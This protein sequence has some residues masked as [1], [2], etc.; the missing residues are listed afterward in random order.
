MSFSFTA[1]RSY[2][3]LLSRLV[4]AA[5]F[6]PVGWNR[7]MGDEHV[8][9]GREARIL[10]ELGVGGASGDRSSAAGWEGPEVLA[11]AAQNVATGTLVERTAPGSGPA[12]Q[13]GRGN[14]DPDHDDQP[15]A[16]VPVPPIQ[17][18]PTPAAPRPADDSAVRAKPIYQDAVRLTERGLGPPRMPAWLPIWFARVAA[19]IELVGAGLLVVGLLSRVW[20][21]GLCAL[22]AVGLYTTS[23]SAALQFGL[24]PLRPEDFNALFSHIGLLALALGLVLTGAGGLSLDGMFVRPDDI[25]LEDERLMGLG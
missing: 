1:A 12:A 10:E 22:I 5:A 21:L 9:E 8:Y 19:F 2:V 15:D 3:P 7:M 20:A 17:V 25:D 4:L 13:V 18:I 24:E 14:G 11:V 16:V 23:W 6:V